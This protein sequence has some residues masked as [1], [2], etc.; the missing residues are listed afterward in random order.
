MTED[1]HFKCSS[2]SLCICLYLGLTHILCVPR[3]VCCPVGHSGRGYILYQLKLI[4]FYL[5]YR[6]TAHVIVTNIHEVQ[7]FRMNISQCPQLSCL[8]L[9]QD[10]V[11]EHH[12]FFRFHVGHMYLPVPGFQRIQYVYYKPSY[13]DS[14]PNILLH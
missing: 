11:I 7:I 1:C 3:Q 5:E 4:L 13:C 8:P 6:G 2:E 9:Q 12:Y 10:P 14:F